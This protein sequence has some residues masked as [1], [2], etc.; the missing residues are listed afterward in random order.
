MEEIPFTAIN[1]KRTLRQLVTIER[2]GDSF[3]KTVYTT[4]GQVL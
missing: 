4:E 3:L 2:F 1:L